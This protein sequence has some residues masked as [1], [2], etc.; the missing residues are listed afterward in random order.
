MG[1]EGRRLLGQSLNGRPIFEPRPT[2]SLMLAAAGG[3]KTTGGAMVWLQSMLAD[4]SRGIIFPDSKDGEV[5]AQAS[6]M[7]ADHGREVAIIDDFNRLDNHPLRVSLNPFGGLVAAHTRSENELLFS[8]ENANHALIE[9]PIGDS[10]NR[11]WRASPR[12]FV[13]FAERSLLGRNAVL[14]TPGGVWSLLADPDVFGDALEIEAEEGAE[15]LR[16]QAR[17]ILSLRRAVPDHFAQH[18]DAALECLRLFEAGSVLHEVGRDADTSHLEL[19]QKNAIVFLVGPQRHMDRLGAYYALHLQSFLEA[20]LTGLAGDTDFILDE[21]TNAPLKT[22]VSKLTTMRAYGGR[23][24]MIAQSRS[25]IERKYGEK[26]TV[27]IEEN[28]IV[29]QWMG[30]SSFEE[31]ER[32]SK[33]MGEVQNVSDSMGLNSDKMDF[34][35]NWSTG[36]E[37]LMSAEELMR[38]PSDEQIIHVKDV[39][40]IRCKKVR[41]NE[42][43]PY[44]FELKDNPLEGG[45]LEPDPKITLP[46]NANE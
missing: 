42:V 40:F 1:P 37:R 2:H 29:K 45:R 33:A 27:T 36:R 21:F 39:G 14:A 23:C 26:E 11:Y 10:K 8:A 41:Q 34:S 28:A 43:G 18:L 16:S 6:R 38:L 7:C 19:L 25:E 13:E 31:A 5:A 46:T 15:P 20:Q 12:S 3:G 17:N 4:H 44:C 30:F 9:E 22:L 35:G 24:H 32:V